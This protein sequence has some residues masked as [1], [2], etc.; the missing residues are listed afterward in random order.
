MSVKWKCCRSNVLHH[1]FIT[2]NPDLWEPVNLIIYASMQKSRHIF[3]LLHLR[4]T[5]CMRL[6]ISLDSISLSLHPQ[7]NRKWVVILLWMGTRRLFACW[8]CQGG[9]TLSLC[10]GR[11]GR[12]EARDTLS[13]VRKA[14]NVQYVE[15]VNVQAEHC[16]VG[17]V[18]T[19]G[20][21]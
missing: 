13:M 16:I 12:T 1:I 6:Y 5:V 19:H 10:Q 3:M 20:L 17:A 11:S 9:T 18:E 2:E 15:G 7:W 21:L 14:V 8:S 4:F